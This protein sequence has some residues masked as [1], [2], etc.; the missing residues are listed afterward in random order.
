MS[1]FERV[2]YTVVLLGQ[3]IDENI[4]LVFEAIYTF[5]LFDFQICFADCR[6][7]LLDGLDAFKLSCVYLKIITFFPKILKL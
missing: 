7:I 2:E 4:E 5:C 1:S 6:Y 3:Y